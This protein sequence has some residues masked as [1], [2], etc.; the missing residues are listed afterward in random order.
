MSGTSETP[1]HYIR[2]KPDARQLC[3][4]API[5]AVQPALPECAEFVH[6]HSIRCD[7]HRI[8]TWATHP[9]RLET[10]WYTSS[11]FAMEPC[12][13]SMLLWIQWDQSTQTALQKSEPDSK[14]AP[15]AAALLRVGRVTSLQAVLGLSIQDLAQ[16]L[17]MS[18]PGLYKW[19]DATR[20]LNLQEASR[21]RLTA[22]ERLAKS[23]RD[24]TPAPLASV[25]TDVLANGHTMIALLAVEHLDEGAI[26][27]GFDELAAKLSGRAKSRS[28]KLAD[29]GF[30][31]RPSARALPPDE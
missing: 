20:D 12:D 28:Q 15:S 30:G 29:A 19:L 8:Q 4:N 21:D 9:L 27:A 17:R 31:R 25:A 11:T 18:R 5:N 7:A 10:K 2:L 16:V 14:P 13:H 24:R 3:S 23:W 6:S 1:R 22:I 26:F